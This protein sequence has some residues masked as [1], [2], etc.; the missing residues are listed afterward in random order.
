MEFT[1]FQELHRILS[2]KIFKSVLVSSVLIA[3]IASG[4]LI[5]LDILKVR[6]EIARNSSQLVSQLES[7]HF[8]FTGQDNIHQSILALNNI[9]AK[10]PVKEFLYKLPDGTPGFH[11][12]KE[13]SAQSSGWFSALFL[14]SLA[15]Y[16]LTPKEGRNQNQ[17]S[18]FI[19][20]DVNQYAERLELRSLIIFCVGLALALLLSIVVSFLSPRL[21]RQQLIK[22]GRTALPKDLAPDQQTNSSYQNST[23][24]K[25][26][27]DLHEALEH[28][29][30]SLLYQPQVNLK[31]KK[32]V[33]AEIL[34]RWQH[35]EKG[36]ISPEQFIPMAENSLDI[37]PIGDWVLESACHQ[38]QNW[39]NSG[40]KH[41]RIAVNLSAIQLKDKNITDRIKY[42][43][44]KYKI[45]PHLLE[46]EITETWLMD[47]LSLASAQLN[48]IKKTGVLLALDD[49]GTGYSSLSYLKQFPFDK[50][51]IDKSF[52]EGLPGN[53]ENS[54]IVDS[55]I[56][57]GNSFGLPVIAEGIEHREQEDHLTQSGC[58]EGQG[59]LYGMPMSSGEM[60]SYLQNH[61]D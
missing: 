33:G 57:L 12:E 3:L 54:V 15:S 38:L 32:V 21:L 49:F 10:A 5:A 58:Y 1:S 30:L 45:P 47:D 41:F 28:H 35:P 55:I 16:Q 29:E 23:Q 39:H 46:L 2:D 34:L 4:L 37:I 26:N 6:E 50:I 51:K 9:I 48:R 40:H 20:I 18:F 43:L 13:S 22:T 53:W 7:N 24:C 19:T 31:E 44:S 11:L 56:Q 27:Q 61:R 52:I 8:S 14:K 42:L 60:T 17:G 36:L 25:L 59:Y